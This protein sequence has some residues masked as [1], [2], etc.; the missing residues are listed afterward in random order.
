[1]QQCKGGI[2][3]NATLIGILIT[4]IFG[5]AGF[6]VAKKVKKKSQKQIVR[7]NS[8][9]IQSGRDTNID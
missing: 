3:D 6:F 7:D 4:I 5:V 2:L 9:A 1:M 8:V